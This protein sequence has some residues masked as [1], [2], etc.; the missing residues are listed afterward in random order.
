[1]NLYPI[2]LCTANSLPRS[3]SP[4]TIDSKTTAFVNTTIGSPSHV[5]AASRELDLD[6]VNEAEALIRELNN[7]RQ[8]L[9][10]DLQVRRNLWILRSDS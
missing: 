1:M 9:E 6:S 4:N 2:F 3:I 10:K 8:Y 5:S 7:S